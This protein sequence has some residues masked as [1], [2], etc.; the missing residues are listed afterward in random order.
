MRPLT[1]FGLIAV[2]IV[3]PSIAWAEPLVQ[4]RTM[5]LYEEKLE[6]PYSN[7]WQATFLPRNDLAL[8]TGS[9]KTVDFYGV[10]S[11]NCDPGGSYDWKAAGNFGEIS[12]NTSMVPKIVIA[13]AKKAWCSGSK[14]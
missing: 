5:S 12:S 10:L 7:N 3:S 9:G 11:F 14:R 4:G 1:L 8:I 6:A 2:S 13:R